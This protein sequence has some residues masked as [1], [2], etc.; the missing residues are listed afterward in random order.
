ML[1]CP[2]I[3]SGLLPGTLLLLLDRQLQPS[4]LPAFRSGSPYRCRDSP[5][6]NLRHYAEFG[7]EI[8]RRFEMPLGETSGEGEV[9]ELKLPRIQ[10]VDHVV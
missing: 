8:R 1:R 7:R 6:A 4:N 3:G 10:R 5:K 2:S 9:V